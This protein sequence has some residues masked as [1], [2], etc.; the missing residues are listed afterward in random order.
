MAVV[1]PL[2]GEVVL[3]PDGTVTQKFAEYLEELELAIGLSEEID[4]NFGTFLGL[5]AQNAALDK[6]VA[7]LEQLPVRNLGDIMK[8]LEDLEQQQ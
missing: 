7:E 2:R 8:R 3:N 1:P 4:E 6:R 5:F